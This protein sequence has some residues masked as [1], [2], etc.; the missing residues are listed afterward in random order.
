MDRGRL[1]RSITRRKQEVG[2][3][4]LTAESR[5]VP[6]RRAGARAST[7]ASGGSGWRCPTRPDCSR[8]RGRR[9]TTTPTSARPRSAWRSRLTPSSAETDGLGAIVIGLPRRLSGEAND[10][11]G[12]VRTL[13]R[14]LGDED[15]RPDYASGRAAHQPR[16]GRT[17]RGARARL[18]QTQAAAR[19]DGR[20]P[21]PAGLSRPSAAARERRRES[22][23]TA[24]AERDGEGHRGPAERIKER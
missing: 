8:R 12:R 7:M 21:D 17:A 23:P 1:Q 3:R 20:G 4:K 2:S 18:A 15:R 14:L 24:S 6:Y 13:A 9:S 16:S 11:T 5:V 10:Q 22:E 19:C